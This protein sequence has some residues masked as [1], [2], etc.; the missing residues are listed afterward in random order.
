MTSKAL[1][2]SAKRGFDFKFTTTT[3]VKELFVHLFIFFFLL[4]FRRKDLCE[5]KHDVV[6]V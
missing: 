3:A 1:F 5:A 2:L 6:C 4:V